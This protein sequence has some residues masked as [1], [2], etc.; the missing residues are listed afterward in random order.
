MALC[1]DIMWMIGDYVKTYRN[2]KKIINLLTIKLTTSQEDQIFN[3][4]KNKKLD[5][6]KDDFI[7]EEGMQNCNYGYCNDKKRK[8]KIHYIYELVSE[9]R[10]EIVR[11]KIFKLKNDF[12]FNKLKKYKNIN[13][14]KRYT[15]N[16]IEKTKIDYLN[17][18]INADEKKLLNDAITLQ[19]N[20]CVARD[21]YNRHI[22]D[23]F[24]DKL[25]QRLKDKYTNE[26]FKYE[27]HFIEMKR[28]KEYC[29]ISICNDSILSPI[30]EYTRVDGCRNKPMGWGY[31]H[32]YSD[33]LQKYH[34]S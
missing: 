9:K 18:L 26:L 2:N 30:G 5:D 7:D 29:T 6:L 21:F 31:I 27:N 33:S 25:K 13:D 14:G 1:D 23:D 34:N 11:K 22:V 24:V 15:K 10:D 16:Q 28:T 3:E 4:Y 17:E 32:L 12:I 19:Q 20:D 8:T